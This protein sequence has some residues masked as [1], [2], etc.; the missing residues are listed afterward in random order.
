MDSKDFKSF[1]RALITSEVG[2]IPTRS[3]QSIPVVELEL[4]RRDLKYGGPAILFLFLI[5]TA[6]GACN[7][8]DLL[9]AAGTT[10]VLGNDTTKTDTTAVSSDTVSTIDTAGAAPIQSSDTTKADTSISRKLSV[11]Q[12]PVEPAYR[13]VL[14]SLLYPGWGQLY[15]RKYLK[16]LAVFSTEATLLGM[17]YTESKE[18]SQ[19]YSAHIVAPNPA[20]S[21]RLYREYEKHFDRR[22]SL[23][24]WT[25]GLLLFSLAD[26]YVDAHLLTFEEEFGQRLEKG[27]IS[28]AAAAEPRRAF[29]GVRCNF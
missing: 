9:K 1:C 8:N 6:T 19:A 25:A 11:R 3:R 27:N 7:G 16:A 23:I 24:W 17:I 26:A 20:T 4:R 22:D 29:I 13:V 5:V 15:N 28:L 18:A 14:R 12:L 10:G 2:S 21:E